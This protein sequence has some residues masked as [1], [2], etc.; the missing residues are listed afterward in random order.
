MRVGRPEHV[1]LIVLDDHVQPIQ[2]NIKATRDWFD[3]KFVSSKNAGERY[4]CCR[5]LRVVGQQGQQ[6][7]NVLSVV[8]RDLIAMDLEQI[9]ANSTK[10]VS[11]PLNSIVRQA[12]DVK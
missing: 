9:R 10:A 4:V 2:M 8:A 5:E 1:V 11:S 3:T 7:W 6:K 12:L